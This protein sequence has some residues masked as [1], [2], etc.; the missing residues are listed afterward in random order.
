LGVLRQS[1]I[2]GVVGGTGRIGKGNGGRRGTVWEL[3]QRRTSKEKEGEP[4][5]GKKEK[6]PEG[7]GR[8]FTAC[9]PAKD[10]LLVTA[11]LKKILRRIAN[12][13]GRKREKP[14]S[15]ITVKKEAIFE[16]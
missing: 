7:E 5:R 10:Q 16:K 4:S 14:H 6:T 8:D 3:G 11:P 1:A 12:K 13:S 2:A 15:A 9:A